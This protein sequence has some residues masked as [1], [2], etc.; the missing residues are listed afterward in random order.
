[1]GTVVAALLDAHPYDEVAYDLVPLLDGAMVGFGR[2]GRLPA[3]RPLAELAATIRD[4]LPAPHLRY[5]GD[6]E[7]PV[8]SRSRSS[9]APATASSVRRSPPASTCT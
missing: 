7:R 5:A 6:P 8:A 4:G 2:V 1:V 9:A 3:P